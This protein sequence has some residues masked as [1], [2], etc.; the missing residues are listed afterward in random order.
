MQGAFAEHQVMLKKVRVENPIKIVL[1]RQVPDLE[2]CDALIIPGGGELAVP[3]LR[4]AI[5][6]VM[7]RVDDH[8]VARTFSRAD[9]ASAR[10]C[11]KQACMGNVRWGYSS[12]KR[13]GRHEGRRPRAY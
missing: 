13:S 5:H 9:R 10:L 7:D 1:I 3:C 4:P 2:P 6:C 8:S 12:L 11:K